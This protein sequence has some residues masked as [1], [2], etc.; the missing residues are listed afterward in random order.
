[1]AQDG[2]DGEDGEDGVV[3]L[4]NISVLSVLSVRSVPQNLRER[5]QVIYRMRHDRHQEIAA[6]RIGP[7]EVGTNQG[8]VGGVGRGEPVDQAEDDRREADG[9]PDRQMFG[10]RGLQHAAEEGLLAHAGHEGDE[11]ELQPAAPREYRR[12]P[13]L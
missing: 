9:S 3:R 6:G 2:Q 12:H 1:M 7:A 4:A 11:R 8:G 10:Q 5:D 13:L